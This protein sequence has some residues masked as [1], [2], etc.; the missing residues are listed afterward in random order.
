MSA[1]HPDSGVPQDLS[2]AVSSTL[3]GFYN[4]QTFLADVTTILSYFSSGDGLVARWDDNSAGVRNAAFALKGLTMILLKKL[5]AGTQAKVCA[6]VLQRM[7]DLLLW[8][9]G[10][11]SQILKYLGRSS[12]RNQEASWEMLMTFWT[13]CLEAPGEGTPY[14]ALLRPQVEI[15]L[16]ISGIAKRLQDSRSAHRED[17]KLHGGHHR[18]DT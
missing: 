2:R 3:R 7:D 6:L 14:A 16:F 18:P 12:L 17:R 15:M 5:Y 11:A 8:V 9:R 1:T 13:S 4:T 10:W